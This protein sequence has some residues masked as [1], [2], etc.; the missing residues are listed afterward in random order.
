[1][2]DR[3]A[4]VD[5]WLEAAVMALSSGIV[6]RAISTADLGCSRVQLQASETVSL[7]SDRKSVV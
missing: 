1:M 6:S 7:E 3:D 5:S 4:Q 2:N